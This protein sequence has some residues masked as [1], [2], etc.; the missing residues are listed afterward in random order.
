MRILSVLSDLYLSVIVSVSAGAHLCLLL[1]P[2][3]LACAEKPFDEWL[4]HTGNSLVAE[5]HGD[6]GRYMQGESRRHLGMRIGAPK[7]RLGLQVQVG[8]LS[9]LIW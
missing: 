9:I 5:I 8:N 3:C 6:C 7:R 1:Y 4:R 2:H